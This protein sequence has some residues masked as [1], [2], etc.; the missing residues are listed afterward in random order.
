[1]SGDRNELHI[2]VDPLERPLGRLLRWAQA[3]DPQRI[4]DT[5]SMTVT[6]VGGWDVSLLLADYDQTHLAP[7]TDGGPANVP[8]R[9]LT[10]DGSLPGR[11]FQTRQI[12]T[13]EREDG[14]QVWVPVA[15]RA[16]R[17]GVLGMALPHWDEQVEGFCEELGIV[18]AHLVTTASGYTDRVTMLRRRSNLSLAAEMQWSILPPQN[19]RYDGTTVS[20]LLEPAYDVGGDCFDYALNGN[21]LDLAV[22]DAMGHGVDSAV[23]AALALAAYRNARRSQE[24]ADLRSMLRQVDHTLNAHSAGN[25][26]VTAVIAQLDIVT[27]RLLWLT[28]GHPGPLHLRGGTAQPAVSRDVALPLGLGVLKPAEVEV[29]TTMLQRGDG[30]L[31]YTDGVIDARDANGE[32]FGEARLRDLL[33]RESASGLEPSEM[34]RRLVHSVLEH[35]GTRLR[36]DASTLYLHWAAAADLHP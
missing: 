32:E 5:L 12:V 6:E 25:A 19:F 8:S 31:L 7:A 3:A 13:V 34:L 22:F 11:A 14:W 33:E 2:P 36:D 24:P 35:H 9:E 28:A 4:V 21:T 27:G 18:A 26:F 20:G 1:V 23:L 15:E 10:I 29:T 16:Q 17:I 30:I